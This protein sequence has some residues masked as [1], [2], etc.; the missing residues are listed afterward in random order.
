MLDKEEESRW[1]AEIEGMTLATIKL[2][3]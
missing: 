2:T 3:G 1:M